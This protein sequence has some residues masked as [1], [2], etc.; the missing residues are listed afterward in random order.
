[1]DNMLIPI[2]DIGGVLIDWDPMNLFRKLFDTEEEAQWFYDNV[3][4]PDWNLGF[5]AGET[6]AEGVIRLSAQFP[7]YWRE[8]QA[9]DQ[10]WPEMVSGLIKGTVSIHDELVTAE[11]PTF[12]ITNFSW[13]KLGLMMPEWDFLGKFDGIVVSGVEKVI[14]PD[15]R[16]Y[17]I[18]L[19]R[20]GLAPESCVFID[21]KPI[22]VAA[23][24]SMGMQGLV[25]T[26][27]ENLRKDLIDL[28][29]PLADKTSKT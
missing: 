9:Y 13:E 19:D 22:N 26:N 21:D 10:R 23:A 6:F 15:T 12:S 27:P 24:Q 8:I 7:R 4:T 3:C 28:G 25:F 17:S 1:M 18:L 29:L 11:V 14:K 5:D 16:I 2:F 20:Y